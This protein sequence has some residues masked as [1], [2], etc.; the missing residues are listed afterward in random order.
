MTKK[1]KTMKNRIIEKMKEIQSI[2]GK[3]FSIVLMIGD[4]DTNTTTELVQT[5]LESGVDIVELG[6]PYANPFL[7]SPVMQESMERALAF[8][9]DLDIYLDY[10]TKARTA[11]PHTAFEVMIYYDTVMQ[12]G[13]D[14][15]CASLGK[16]EM[17]AVLVA[18]YVLQDE[19]FLK[20]LDQ[21]L[22]DHNVLHIR[23]VP[24]PFKPEQIRDLNQ[25]GRGFIIAQT[26]TNDQ[27]RR[28]E[29]L[30]KNKEKLEYLR[31][32]GVQTPLVSAYGIKTPED[33]KKCITL[34]ADGVLLGTVV[35]EAAYKLPREK[36][37]NLL[38]NLRNAASA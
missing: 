27:G 30:G 4:P 1:G 9:D 15:F 3:S 25:N 6:I 24:H 8:S 10:L 12:I 32:A 22:A 20:Q 11:F 18:D 2:G 21:K 33:V 37:K 7:D 34:G 19:I 35:L 17:D 36:F 31:R 26:I 14:K 28:N 38:L 5:A 23:F 29:V 13:L 16:A